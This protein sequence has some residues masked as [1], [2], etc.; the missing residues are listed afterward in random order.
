[1]KVVAMKA[2]NLDIGLVQCKDIQRVKLAQGK[3]ILEYL[4]EYCEQRLAPLQTFKPSALPHSLPK[5]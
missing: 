4:D 5:L 3:P 2:K 1:M